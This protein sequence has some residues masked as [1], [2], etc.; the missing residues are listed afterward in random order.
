MALGGRDRDGRSI[1]QLVS[2]ITE[3]FSALIRGE[4]ELA[5]AE[6]RESAQK[7][8][9]GAGLFAA[10]GLLAFFA[11]IFL[12]VAAAYGLVAAGLPVWAG[13]LIVALV[14]LIIAGILGF[15]G[16]RFFDR[17]KGPERAKAQQEATKRVLS[18]VP[19]RFKDATEKAA[20]PAP[21]VSSVTPVAA[22]TTAASPKPTTPSPATAAGGTTTAKTTPTPAATTTDVAASTTPSADKPVADEATTTSAAS[23]ATESD[24]PT[25]RRG[26]DD[27]R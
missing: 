4:I 23:G 12:L 21:T 16:K 19:Q 8:G 15:L 2:S 24:S 13:F 7:A 18:S 3:D 20:N 9:A 17:V 5:K 26:D 27:E 14:L 6:M 22:P 10:A 11:F 1:G 25:V